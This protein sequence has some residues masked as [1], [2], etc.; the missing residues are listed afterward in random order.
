MANP[1]AKL[2][3]AGVLTGSFG[4]I[5][6][7]GAAALRLPW[8]QGSTPV[9]FLDCLFTSTSAVCVTGLITVDT[10]SAWN[11][12]GKALIAALI[13][14]GGLGIM[15]FSM[16]MVFLAGK[17]PS[18]RTHL[19]LRGALGPV[20]GT[21]IGRLARDVI[22]YT[23]V[24][25][26]IGFLLLWLRFGQDMDW[27]SAMGVAGFHAVSA[28]CNAGF[29]TFSDNLEQ[30]PHDPLINLV[31]MALIVLGG[32]G[33][34]V[35]R[36]TRAWI[37]ARVLGRRR[38]RLS[39]HTRTVLYTTAFLIVAGAGAIY[40]LEWL[41]NGGAVWKGSLWPVI[42]AAVTP[43]TAG[44]DTIA[45][46]QLSNGTLLF[47]ILLMFVGGSP[48][49]CAGGIKTTT[50]ATLVALARSKLHGQAGVSLGR[51]S[52]P[53]GQVGEAT[54]LVLGSTM[55]V[56]LAVLFLASLGG[57]LVGHDRGEVLAFAFEA[58]SAFGTVGLSMGITYDLHP[59]AKVILILL[60]FIG[61]LGPLTL[62]YMLAER[63]SPRRFQLAEERI[64]LG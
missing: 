21:E 1:I 16:A 56:V 5:I 25:E 33:F 53:P 64:M 46:A 58:V 14:A 60:M 23:L 19:A 29:S 7:L 39:L 17:K 34:V 31:I 2:S 3:P 59:Q 38:P 45:P 51:R 61:R 30:Y 18:I 35:L 22:L 6:L 41:S 55:V 20:P 62:I 50:L 49:S 48:G 54:T 47:T 11:P 13:Q 27:L 42:F 43:R 28:F 32:L 36:E 9:S 63:Y 44:F 15:T 40:L 4:V 12:W 37:A 52:L 10:A 24:I 8:V 26:S 57:D